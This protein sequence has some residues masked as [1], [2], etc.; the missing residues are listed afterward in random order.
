MGPHNSPSIRFQTNAEPPM[1]TG[2]RPSRSKTPACARFVIRVRGAV[3]GVGFRPF[4]HR[5][6]TGL[7]LAG[8][9]ANS[10][11]GVLIEAEGERGGLNAL[12][13]AIRNSAPR[14]AT[15]TQIQV[16]EARPL[17]ETTFA[18][19]P[20]A[21]GGSRAAQVLP[22]LAP[23]E[24]CLAELFDPSDRR[25]GYPFINCTQCGP[26]FSIIEDLPY[27]RMR[28][29]MRRFEMCRACAA[30]YVDPSSR[31]FHAEP[32]ACPDCGPRLALWDRAGGVLAQDHEALKLAIVAIDQGQ[33]LAIKGVGG[34]H[35]LVDARNEAAVRRLRARKRRPDK[36]FAVMFPGIEA[37]EQNCA[38][39][40]AERALLTGPER[41][42]VLLG[43][44]GASVAD[45]V[46]PANPLVGAILPYSPL[47]H[48]LMRALGFAVVATSGN[49]SD[50][51]IAIDEC[52][53]VERLGEIADLFL[54][55]DRPIVR[56]AED[57]VARIVCDRPL[58]LRRARGYAP[59][60][61]RVEGMSAGVLGLG[62]HLKTTVALSV[63]GGVV[64]WP[65][66]GDLAT[67]Q[68]R[69]AHGRA[70]EDIARLHAVRPRIVACDLHPDYASTKMA[71]TFGAPVAPVQHHL[72]H[73][74]A[75]MADNGA[76]APLLGVAWDGAGYGSDATIWGGEF[77]RIAE[78]GWR[79]VAHLRPFRL[80]G[81]EAAAREPRRAAIGLLYAAF[82]DEALTM[83]DLAPVAA[84]TVAERRTLGAVLTRGV[85]APFCS[86]IG[87]LFDAVAA[88]AGLRQRASFEG[89]AASELEWASGEYACG[90][91]Y[92]FAIESS[93]TDEGVLVVDWR[94]ALLALL[95]DV[96]AGVAMG[97]ISQ[98]LH[99]GL[100]AAIVDV[101][102]RVGERRVA[103][104]GGCFQNAYL[105][106]AAVAGLSEA[107][108][109][110]LW[111]RSIPPNDG[112]LAL[113][114][115]VWAAWSAGRGERPCA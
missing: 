46:A 69:S 39:S 17:G 49:L 95:A 19:R 55:H 3:Q 35:L 101:A 31:R 12:V 61:V 97:Q 76:A 56:P 83:D 50:E 59:A 33:I 11:E 99:N 74:V 5:Q 54:V 77:I 108:F 13:D 84:F 81:G 80:P 7:G 78:D 40:P 86:S 26:R 110:P 89:Q 52:E 44:S 23:C 91:R 93:A 18:I 111:H 75:C 62:G 96:R 43:R 38:V 64:L 113:G 104:T 16:A 47:H 63:E 27:D 41:P 6:A 28:T 10:A 100:A 73:V 65:H 53:A 71:E 58:M 4:V 22:D 103:L 15:V 92:D 32:I 79:R 66:V 1:T 114:Q 67:H 107:G 30:E 42:I 48:L 106:E 88:L 21:R 57:S 102:V 94:P 90:R 72:A 2:L 60:P 98:A 115:A 37:L 109:E 87:R 68:A 24:A 29:T 25:R 105:T 112:G 20:S 45:G 14:H 9:V 8:W 85:N 51:P 34:F 36:P 70:A 82:G